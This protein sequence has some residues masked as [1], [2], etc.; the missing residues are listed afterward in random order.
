MFCNSGLIRLEQLDARAHREQKLE[1]L[2]LAL[3][4]FFEERDRQR[5]AGRRPLPRP[6]AVRGR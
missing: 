4:A 5:T 6:L 1:N 2:G 3:A